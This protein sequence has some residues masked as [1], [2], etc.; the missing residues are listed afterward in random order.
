MALEDLWEG[1]AQGPILGP[2][3][4]VG[5]SSVTRPLPCPAPLSSPGTTM[6]A[7]WCFSCMTSVTCSW[8]SPSSMS[9]S[10]PAEGLTIHC[11]P[12]LQT[13]AA[14]A[15]AS[16]GELGGP[17]GKRGACGKGQDEARRGA[18]LVGVLGEGR[19]AHAGK[20]AGL[21]AREGPIREVGRACG[22]GKGQAGKGRS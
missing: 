2:Q 10:S 19:Q 1:E 7:F 14:S 6:W 4:K 18:G 12:W 17:T 15:S 5:I 8:S 16:A 3:C 13:W 11:T 20:K 9:I 21:V 22:K